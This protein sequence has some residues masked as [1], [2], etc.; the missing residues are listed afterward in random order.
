MSQYSVDVGADNFKKVVL[1]GS[2]NTPVIIDFWAPWCA[3]CRALKPILEKLAEEY[4]G[5][6]ILAKINSDENQEIAASLGVRSIPAVKAIV[7]GKVADEFVGALPER[8]VKAF[9]ERLLPTPSDIARKEAANL[10]AAGQTTEALALLDQALLL[11]PKNELAR[12]ERVEALLAL[13]RVD[14][15]RAAFAQ[16]NTVYLDDNRVS[17]LKARLEFADQGDENPAQFEERIA[18]NPEDLDARLQLARHC[19]RKQAYEPAL[20]QLME[21]V[22]ADRKFGDD[23][24]RKTMIDVFNL[25]G[26][27]GDLVSKYRRLLSSALY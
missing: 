21:I 22:R 15:A 2:K 8:Q 26:G 20:E 27:Q 4:A 6:F 1:E 24:G 7:D 12:V 23:I 11:S 17:A 25:L 13:K 10:M 3:P 14:E 16:I 5:R 9:I 19:V 18:A